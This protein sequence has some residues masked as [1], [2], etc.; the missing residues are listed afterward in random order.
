MPAHRQKSKSEGLH[1]RLLVARR[2]CGAVAAFGASSPFNSRGKEAGG[3]QQEVPR[4]TRA[5]MDPHVLVGTVTCGDRHGWT[6]WLLMA[7][8]WVKGPAHQCSHDVPV[9]LVRRLPGETVISY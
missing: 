7:Y 8:E 1:L 4:R 5:E 2:C 3:V 6:G 9:D